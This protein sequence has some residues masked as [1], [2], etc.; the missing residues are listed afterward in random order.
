MRFLF[1]A[2][3]ISYI[4]NDFSGINIPRATDYI[5]SCTTYESGMGQAPGQEAH[6]GSTFCAVASLY[7]MNQADQFQRR[8]G[9]IEW[10]LARQVDG[11]QGRVSKPVDTCYSFWIGGSLA[12]FNAYEFVDK[13]ANIKYLLSAQTKYGGFAKYPTYHPDLMH[14]YMGLAGLALSGQEGVG[15]LFAGL[16]ISNRA[17]EFLKKKTV[18]WNRQ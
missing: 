1:C 13:D 3:A 4:L 18:W 2:C 16:N 7:L 14:A 5:R 9:T 6:G 12:L 17:F 15:S 11:F 8:D 10:C